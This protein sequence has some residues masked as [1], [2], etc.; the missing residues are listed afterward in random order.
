[1]KKLRAATVGAAA[2][3]VLALAGPT[4]AA[5][6]T[7]SYYF[8]DCAGDGPSNFY[9]V[10]TATPTVSGAPVSSAAAFQLTDGSATYSIL[11]FGEGNFDPQG[12]RDN[13]SSYNLVCLVDF[14]GV[15]TTTVYGYFAPTP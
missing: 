8:Y 14:V 13:S 2:V 11:S 9:A 1:M 10:K 6:P 5:R 7:A 4:M 15:G 3:S 12:I